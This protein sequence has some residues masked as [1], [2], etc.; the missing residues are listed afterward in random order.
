MPRLQ[1]LYPS[2][3]SALGRGR[4]IG[5]GLQN[6]SGMNNHTKPG[7]N[8]A[9]RHIPNPSA[10]LFRQQQTQN[11]LQQQ[12]QQQ[13]SSA[14]SRHPAVTKTLFN[15]FNN[16]STTVKPVSSTSLLPTSAT[17][18]SSIRKM[19]NMTRNIEKVAAGLTVRAVE[20]H[21]K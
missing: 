4:G 19:E 10:L 11:R 16:T 21:S 5:A 7:P 17:P 2:S 6:R 13:N 14:Q 15:N 1:E 3:H 8:Q 18:V 9:V 12:Q 20:A